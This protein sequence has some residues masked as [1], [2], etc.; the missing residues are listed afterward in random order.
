MCQHL[1]VRHVTKI[2]E[3]IEINNVMLKYGQQKTQL[4][5]PIIANYD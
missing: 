3:I 4:K 1:V 2:R 5:W